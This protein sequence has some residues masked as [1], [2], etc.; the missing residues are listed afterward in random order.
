MSLRPVSNQHRTQPG[1]VA[2]TSHFAEIWA[3]SPTAATEIAPR[4]PVCNRPRYERANRHSAAYSRSS[5]RQHNLNPVM[6]APFLAGRVGRHPAARSAMTL[7][8]K[9]VLGRRPVRA[10]EMGLITRSVRQ[11]EHYLPRRCNAPA[12][13]NRSTC[14]DCHRDK[15]HRN[16]AQSGCRIDPSGEQSS[17]VQARPVLWL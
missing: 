2:G 17:Y 10:A 16:S 11:R 12:F 7:Q 1:W 13:N 3:C 8:P 6:D 9:G 15:V 14:G 5:V 4:G